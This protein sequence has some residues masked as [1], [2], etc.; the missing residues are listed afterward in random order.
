MNFDVENENFENVLF[1][2]F[3]SQNILGDENNDPDINFFNEKSEA[4]NSPYYNADKFN[5]SSRNLLK[6]SFSVLHINI[7]SMNKNFEKL[8]EYLSHVKGHFSIIAL[9]ETRCSDNK[10]DENSLWQLPNY[11][12]IHQI[13]NSGQKGGGIA[14]YVHNSLNYKTPKNKNIDNNDIEC[15]N[16]EIVSKAS[17]NVVIFCIYRPRRG[18]VHKFL[19]E[20]KGHIIKN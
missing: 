6:N 1:N 19:S 7:R 17:K 20:M 10:A 15:L 16:I 4:V 3:D 11:R 5:S 9:T 12:T 8:R 18:D 13:R 14:L 2:P